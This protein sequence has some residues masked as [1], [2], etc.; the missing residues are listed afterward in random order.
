MGQLMGWKWKSTKMVDFYGS[1]LVFLAEA[2]RFELTEGLPLRWFQDQ[3]IKPLWHASGAL[4][5]AS[6]VAWD[7]V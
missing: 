6:V 4:R 2:V 3:S 5:T 7:A 1:F